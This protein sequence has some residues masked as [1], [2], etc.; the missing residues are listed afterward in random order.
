MV[1]RPN[2]VRAEPCGPRQKAVPC[3]AIWAEPRLRFGRRRWPNQE[4]R[5]CIMWAWPSSGNRS[6]P[7]RCSIWFGAVLAE[8]YGGSAEGVAALQDRSVA[9]VYFGR[10]SREGRRSFVFAGFRGW[11]LDGPR[12]ERTFGRAP[13]YLGE[14]LLHYELPSLT[15]RVSRIVLR[16]P[17]RRKLLGGRAL[18]EG[19]PEGTK[20]QDESLCRAP[21]PGLAVCCLGSVRI[22]C[23]LA[24]W[25]IR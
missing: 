21:P 16:V 5:R 10:T 17:T 20:R 1:Y 12:L 3:L 8:P 25:F 2:L 18:F 22:Q 24:L 4:G 14:D 15:R 7:V 19:I 9:G 13:S 23:A 11:R 6:W